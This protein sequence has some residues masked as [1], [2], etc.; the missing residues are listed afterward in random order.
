MRQ[1]QSHSLSD[2]FHRLAW[3]N[4]FAQSAEQIALAA[5]PMVAV[6]AL[7][8]TESQVG[9]LQFMLTL[10]FLLIAIPAGLLADR[11]PRQRLMAY[12]ETARALSLAGLVALLA[13]DQ[14]TLAS[15]AALGLVG[16]CGTV[17]FTVTAPALVPALVPSPLF[18]R[19]NARLEVAGT[20]AFV[21]GPATASFRG[22]AAQR[23][24]WPSVL[25]AAKF[26]QAV[27]K[28]RTLRT[29]LGNASRSDSGDLSSRTVRLTGQRSE[30]HSLCQ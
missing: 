16:V 2:N 18:G 9:W 12:A 10:P 11:M 13:A 20:S 30:P 28:I 23:R 29:Q 7:G 24:N 22:I 8:A 6:L 15:L 17:V 4:L 14:L 27:S 1:N 25:G 5:S 21:A 3:S 26:C 19:A